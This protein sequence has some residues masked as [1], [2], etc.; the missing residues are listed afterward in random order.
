LK[1]KVEILDKKI[2]EERTV[3]LNLGSKIANHHKLKTQADAAREAYKKVFERAE[4]FQATA[5]NQSDYVAIQERASPA[6]AQTTSSLLPIWKLW[7]PEKKTEKQMDVKKAKTAQ[8]N[9]K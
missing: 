8:A 4:T 3:A 2:E 5:V 1:R 7:T 9:V 6:T